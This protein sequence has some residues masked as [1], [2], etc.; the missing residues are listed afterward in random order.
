MAFLVPPSNPRLDGYDISSWRLVNHLPFDGNFE[1]KFQSM[2]L[3]LSFTDF[4]LPIDVG[5]RGLR[6]TLAILLESVV[7]AN[8]GANHIGDL[9][10]NAMF[11]N[12]GLVMAPKC[13]HKSKS[14]EQ[15][16]AEKRFVSIDSWAE[17]LDL[18]ETTGIFRANG[19]WQARLAAAS[20]GVQLGKKLAILPP[21]PCLQCLNAID[22][23]QI[24]LIIA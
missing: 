14:T 15:L 1:D 20:A 19:N 6:D 2:S 7:S 17:F 24:D 8:D 23:S 21:K 12:D 16:N 22:T 9:D 3:H 18:P 4:E 10:I 13:T 5:V 11:R